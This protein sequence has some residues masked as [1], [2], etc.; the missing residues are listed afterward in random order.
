MY[1]NADLCPSCSNKC[2]LVHSSIEIRSRN[3]QKKEEACASPMR[4]T[5]DLYALLRVLRSAFDLDQ[6]FSRIDAIT[7]GD[8]DGYNLAGD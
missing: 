7:L 5:F 1:F 6:Y 8:V 4:L 2:N 3:T